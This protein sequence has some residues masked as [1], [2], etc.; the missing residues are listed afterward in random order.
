MQAF[1]NHNGPQG[2]SSHFPPGDL[3]HNYQ[4]QIPANLRPMAHHFHE[5][6]TKSPNKQESSRLSVD[7]NNKEIKDFVEM[8]RHELEHLNHQLASKDPAFYG[9]VKQYEKQLDEFHPS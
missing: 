3:R 4:Q 1:S 8:K 7:I 9:L 6:N 2:H 5:T